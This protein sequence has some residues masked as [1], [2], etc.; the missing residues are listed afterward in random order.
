[1]KDVLKME[2]QAS[3]NFTDATKYRVQVRN[4]RESRSY[5]SEF[6][7]AYSQLLGNTINQQLIKTSNL[8]ADFWYT[9]WVDAG[10]P[11]LKNLFS[12]SVNK[13]LSAKL[14]TE[15]KSFKKN[16]LLK[17]KLLISRNQT[18]TSE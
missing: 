2:T 16:E 10:K 3:K 5:T 13:V 18:T 15:C 12:V 4:G 14:K 9:S 7:K 6:A 8:I 1:M 17:N 11:D